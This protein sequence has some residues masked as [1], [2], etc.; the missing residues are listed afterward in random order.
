MTKLASSP[1]VDWNKFAD[2]VH[3]CRG[4]RSKRQCSLEIGCS[5]STLVR[6]ELGLCCTV[7]HYLALCSWMQIDPMKFFKQPRSL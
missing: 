4:E 3:A 5:H 6:V 1:K 7:E 2:A